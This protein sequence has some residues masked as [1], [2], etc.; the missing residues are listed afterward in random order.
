[1]YHSFALNDTPV[2]NDLEIEKA[3]ASSDFNYLKITSNDDF[4]MKKIGARFGKTKFWE[5]I[6]KVLLDS[7][8]KKDEL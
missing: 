4:E 8:N 6:E 1:M 3:S 5:K 7:R 2:F